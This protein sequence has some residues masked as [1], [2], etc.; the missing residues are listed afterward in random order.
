[1]EG[2][3]PEL[4]AEFNPIIYRSP[5]DDNQ[6][7]IEGFPQFEVLSIPG[8]TLDH[9]AFY[10]P[11]KVFCG[12]TLFSAGC[13]R[14]FEGSPRE[15]YSSLQKIA[16]LPEHTEIYCGHEY[17]LNNLKFA[18]KVDPGNLSIKEAIRDTEMKIISGQPSLP[19]NLR[20]EKA[21]NPFLRCEQKEVIRQAE[22][23]AGRTLLDAVEVFSVLREWKN[24]AG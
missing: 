7:C 18:E 21:I 17:T 19:S 6:I 24:Q 8:H 14:L 3:V 13:G 1:M 9:V 23:V 16:A 2:G 22:A 4:I 20:L 11:H 5:F 12:D 15:M 10:F